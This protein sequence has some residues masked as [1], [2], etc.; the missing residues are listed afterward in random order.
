[1]EICVLFLAETKEWIKSILKSILNEHCFRCSNEWK[2]PVFN[3]LCWNF[4]IEEV[5]NFYSCILFNVNFIQ[6][7]LFLIQLESQAFCEEW[8]SP[9][10]NSLC[11]YSIFQIV[12]QNT[13][14][15]I[16]FILFIFYFV[17]F[18]SNYCMIV[19]IH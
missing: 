8:F 9:L 15:I 10:L 13:Y 19:K 1:M 7:L 14:L 3:V 6:F 18:F 5:Y 16:F 2:I 12:L 17:V 4:Y 11:K